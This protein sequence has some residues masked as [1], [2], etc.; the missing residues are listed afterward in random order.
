[1]GYVKGH[2]RHKYHCHETEVANYGI[3]S[4]SLCGGWTT[5]IWIVAAEL[6]PDGSV[7]RFSSAPI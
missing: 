4:D 6:G 3:S 7:A 1:M 5:T 2:L